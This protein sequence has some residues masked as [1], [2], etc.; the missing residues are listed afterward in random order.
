MPLRIYNTI[1]R[2]KEDFEPLIPDRVMMYVCGVTVYDMC[3]IGHARS[4]VTFDVIYR[5]LAKKGYHVVY[6]RNFTDVD[7]KIINRANQLGENWKDLAERFIKEFHSDM[8]ALG[9]LRP[10]HEPKAT[11]HISQIQDLIAE[12]ISNGNAYEI[13]GDVMF[14]VNSFSGYGKLSGKKIDELIAGSRVDVDEKKRDP[15]DF[16]L[17][18]AAKPG[19]PYWDSPWGPG[20]PGWHIECSAMSMK[21]LGRNF[22]IHGGGADLMFPHHENEIAQSEAAVGGQ[23]AKY[24]IHNG[25]VNIRSEKMSKSLGNVLN[26]RETLKSV[27]PETLR[28][29]LLSSHYRS[30][31]DYS[32]NSIREAAVG[33]E[34]LYG[35]MV[36]LTRLCEAQ[37]TGSS[38]PEELQDI[39]AKFCEAM[40]DDF[41]AA[42]AIA[43]LF[44]AARAINRIAGES[45]SKSEDI[46]SAE[47]LKKILEEIRT[48]AGDVL[49]VLREAPAK[50]LEQARMAGAQNLTICKDEIESMIAE[51]N[52]AR[53]E[54]NFARADEI[55][56][57]LDQQGIHLED[58]PKGTS[59]KVKDP[60]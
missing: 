5:Y 37:G 1:T 9:C 35:A 57:H 52:Q 11:D 36:Q 8:D 51:R 47:L 32:D 59:W 2:C 56:K 58:S 55:R 49:G 40:D 6:V 48:L 42:K 29:F 4:V 53:K 7:D 54:K 45:S 20:R 27:H 23:F 39:S 3:H 50:F 43:V 18:K 38:V 21:Y 44:D 24:W 46:P 60:Q 41:N 14:S 22:D 12:L 10:S 25:F 31:L 34:R 13:D 17:W 19:E 33:L 30:P 15:L 28:M 16:A 26:I